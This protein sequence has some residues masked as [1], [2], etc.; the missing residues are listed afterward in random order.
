[1]LNHHN[2][3]INYKNLKLHLRDNKINYLNPR[4]YLELTKKVMFNHL[5]MLAK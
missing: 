3:K 1:M 4:K 5:K 2:H